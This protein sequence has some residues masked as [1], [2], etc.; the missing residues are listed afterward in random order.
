MK[1]FQDLPIFVL[2]RI[3][4]KLTIR[5]K[6]NLLFASEGNNNLKSRMLALAIKKRRLICPLCILNRGTDY[7]VG[8]ARPTLDDFHNQV[9]NTDY[10]DINWKWLN[11]QSE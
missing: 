4:K 9:L 2:D 1:K 6:E 5:D 7:K 11:Y 8:S 3:V 10:G